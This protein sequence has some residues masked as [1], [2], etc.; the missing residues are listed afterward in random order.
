MGGIEN[1]VTNER[2]FNYLNTLADDRNAVT[3]DEVR[4]AAKKY[5]DPNSWTW[6]IVGDL[7]IIEEDI[8][9]LN[10]GPVEIIHL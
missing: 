10:I 6:V 8:K 7:S 2:D 5:I 1:I 4:V 9:N 3:L